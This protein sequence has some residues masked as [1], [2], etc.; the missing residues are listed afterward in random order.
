M[1]SLAL[2]LANIDPNANTTLRVAISQ[3]ESRALSSDAKRS[4]RLA[5]ALAS[6]TAQLRSRRACFAQSTCIG[7]DKTP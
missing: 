4:I 1:T 3:R 2:W 6:M 5:A 7:N